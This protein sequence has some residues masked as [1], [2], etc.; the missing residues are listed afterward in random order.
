MIY[1]AS[2]YVALP[3]R[4]RLRTWTDSGSRYYGWCYGVCLQEQPYRFAPY[5]AAMERGYNGLPMYT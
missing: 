1:P 5:Y 3:L 4:G 2:Y